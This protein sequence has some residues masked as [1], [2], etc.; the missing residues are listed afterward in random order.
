LGQ[1]LC[2]EFGADADLGDDTGRRGFILRPVI[3]SRPVVT[4]RSGTAIR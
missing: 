2:V 3:E 1:A 4:G